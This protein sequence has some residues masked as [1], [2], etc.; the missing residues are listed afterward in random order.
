MKFDLTSWPD[1]DLALVR[2][3]FQDIPMSAYP[4]LAGYGRAGIHEGLQGQGGLFL[5]HDMARLLKLEP[6]MRI[7]DLACGVGTTTIYLAKTFGAHVVAVDEEEPGSLIRK[8]S[9][10]GLEGLVTFVRADARNLP[11]PPRSFD[12]IFS[13]NAFFYFGVDEAYP[14]YLLTFLKDGGE[15]V[16]GSP[17]YREELQANTPEEFLLEYPVC[18]A[19]HSPGWWRSHFARTGMVEVLRSEVHPL[20]AAFWSDRVRF[21]LE[22]QRPADMSEAMGAMVYAII[23]MLN[24][25]ED[26][27]VTHFTLHARKR[28]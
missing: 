21:L 23:R 15:V 18:L 8:A 16:I 24:R 3:T 9:E 25:D 12:A 14:A 13:M 17:C 11:F 27:S 2:S 7:L 28:A 1:V 22:S 6:G 26:G 4:A 20:G 5:A 19:V 10:T